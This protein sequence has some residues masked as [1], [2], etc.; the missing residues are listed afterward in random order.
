MV[1]AVTLVE[2]EAARREVA[3]EA[4]MEEGVGGR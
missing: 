4:P 3:A 2:M 1:A